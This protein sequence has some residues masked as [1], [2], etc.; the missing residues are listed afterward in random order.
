MKK[1]FSYLLLCS[2]VLIAACKKSTCDWN[3]GLVSGKTFKATKTVETGNGQ[4]VDITD[5]SDPC[6]ATTVTYTESRVAYS[7]S[8]AC[9]SPAFGP[10]D[11]GTYA[12][13][14]ANGKAYIV[15]TP[16]GSI[17]PDTTEVSSYDCSSYTVVDRSYGGIG[18]TAYVTYSKE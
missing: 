12:L 5:P 9:A 6:A 13:V 15:V 2:L 11:N 8:P 10:A 3:A 14:Q 16:D 4:T 7:P 17:W 1:P 18:I